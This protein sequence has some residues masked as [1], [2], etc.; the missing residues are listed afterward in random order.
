MPSVATARRRFS[1]RGILILCVGAPA[2]GI[3]SKLLGQLPTLLMSAY[4][5][6]LLCWAI[7]F[8]V[9]ARFLL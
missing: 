2:W 4:P 8:L 6:I 3:G 7:R 5:I 9:F 1:L